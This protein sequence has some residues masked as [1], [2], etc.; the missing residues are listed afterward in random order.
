MA[1]PFAISPDVP[2]S[3]P[4]VAAEELVDDAVIEGRVTDGGELSHRDSRLIEL[5]GCT[6]R[7]TALGHGEWR[8]AT[9]TDQEFVDCDLGVLSAPEASVRQSRFTRCRMSGTTWS[10]GSWQFVEVADCPADLG[11][12]RHARLDRVRFVGCRMT[13]A[14]FSGARLDR[15]EFVDCDL[16]DAE[17][18]EARVSAAGFDDCRIAGATGLA[19]LRR[20]T[21]RF[22]DPIDG[23]GLLAPLA[24]GLGITVEYGTPT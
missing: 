3:G 19:S 14:D 16:S 1:R 13:G 18:G 24:D 12:W 4:A 20:A 21:F 7:S 10:G 6:W 9:L 8:K 15:V 23:L 5:T 17:F 11:T 22:R 2:T